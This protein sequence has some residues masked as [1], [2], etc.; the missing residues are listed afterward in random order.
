M[1]S[2]PSTK[3]RF[4]ADAV[5]LRIGAIA[6]NL[7]RLATFSRRPCNGAAVDS[8]IQ[9]SRFFI[10]WTARDVTEDLLEDLATC[11]R[12][13]TRWHRSFATLWCDNERRSELSQ[14]AREWSDRLIQRSGLLDEIPDHAPS[15]GSEESSGDS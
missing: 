9:E 5:P 14:T 7:A 15:T 13:L 2:H 4:L 11:Q 3:S 6:A 10:D 1:K 12:M 8:V